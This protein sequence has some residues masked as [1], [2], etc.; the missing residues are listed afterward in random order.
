M[1]QFVVGTPHPGFDPQEPLVDEFVEGRDRHLVVRGDLVPLDTQA[2]SAPA[3]QPFLAQPLHRPLRRRRERRDGPAVEVAEDAAEPFDPAEVRGFDGD[4]V[5][6]GRSSLLGEH[7]SLDVLTHDLEL[8]RVDR[9]LP[10]PLGETQ[11][12]GAFGLLEEVEDVAGCF[13]AVRERRGV[14]QAVV[15]H[16]RLTD[17]QFR[18]RRVERAEPEPV[19][20]DL[21]NIVGERF[22]LTERVLADDDAELH[23]RH[24]HVRRFGEFRSVDRSVPAH[25]LPELPDE[26]V[27]DVGVPVEREELLELVEHDHELL[28]SIAAPDLQGTEQVPQ[29]RLRRDVEVETRCSLDLDL[30]VTDVGLL[31][32]PVDRLD[33]AEVG[34]VQADGDRPVPAGAQAMHHAGIEQ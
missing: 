9:V 19:L 6:L 14:E 2:P 23:V 24:R 10:A 13:L 8:G 27:A 4:D 18:L 1:G 28:E 5:T 30:G 25:D 3:D 26:P 33:G 21:R 11:R 32:L 29:R 22:Q 16:R 12:R 15:H 20:H 17:R 34:V 31:D 7:A